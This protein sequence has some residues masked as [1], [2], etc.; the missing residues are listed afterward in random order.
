MN[1]SVRTY[2]DTLSGSQR[3]VEDLSHTICLTGVAA[4][5]IDSKAGRAGTITT[6]TTLHGSVCVGSGRTGGKAGSSIEVEPS[7]T[8]GAGTCASLTKQAE[9]T[10]LLAVI[11]NER[12]D[13]LAIGTG[14]GAIGSSNSQVIGGVG[15][16]R[17]HSSTRE[18]VRVERTI[19]SSTGN[20]A[21]HASKVCY[22]C[23]SACRAVE[24]A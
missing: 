12:V 18:A 23:I 6:K 20:I 19:A 5:S 4:R 24:H 3:Q 17:T 16:C 15:A 7:G 22:V 1:L 13:V 9:G 10:T 14:C 8:T 11:W 2:S 21:Y